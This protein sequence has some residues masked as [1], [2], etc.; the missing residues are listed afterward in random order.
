MINRRQF[1][2]GSALAFTTALPSLASLA[3]ASE[4]NEDGLHIQDWFLQT[5]LEIGEDQKEMSGQNKHLAI[6]FEQKGCPY[7][8]EM[9]NVN[10]AN[11]KIVNYIKQHFGILQINM[12][13][14]KV[15]TGLDGSEMEEKE[16]ARKWRV[17]FTPTIVF[18]RQGDLDGVPFSLA[19]AVEC[20]VI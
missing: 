16:L 8:K 19:Q 7:C 10:F 1:N 14:S 13:G 2:I 20:R 3:N 5:F 9:H 11:D 15:V 4:I 18:L 17:N 6:L 12:W